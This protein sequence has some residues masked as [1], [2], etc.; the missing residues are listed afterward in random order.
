MSD[1]WYLDEKLWRDFYP[2]LFSDVLFEQAETQVDQIF[3]LIGH[4]PE[5]VLDLACGPG[6][7]TLPLLR[8]GC[9]VTAVDAS[10]FLLDD[11]NKR[12]AA[13]SLTAD[14]QQANMLDFKRDQAF[15]LAISMYT[16]FGYFD[17]PDDDR[18][19]LN[20]VCHS[21]REGGQLVI[22][23]VG[24]EYLT[25][26]I[27][28]VTAREFGEDSILVEQPRLENNMSKMVNDWLLIR[29]DEVFRTSFSHN[30]YSA[31]ELQ[32]RLFEAGFT[33]VAIYG[34]LAGEDYDIDAE[35]LVV[36]AGK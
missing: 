26:H 7:H 13:E 29:G 10:A 21:L 23:V 2:C 16:S 34:G 8:A 4:K 12:L 9:T 31:I 19:V 14:V 28:P 6:R 5:Q 25:R 36:V 27:E 11:L 32:D 35:R 22:D 30:V 1:N 3:R 15:D 33:S 20:N 17:A 24:K 18:R